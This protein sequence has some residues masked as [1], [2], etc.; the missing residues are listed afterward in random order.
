MIINAFADLCTHFGSDLSLASLNRRIYKDTE[1]GASISV[2]GTLPAA[3]APADAVATQ[4]RKQS[5]EYDRVLPTLM[6]AYA[7]ATPEDRA[8]IEADDALFHTGKPDAIIAWART[9]VPDAFPTATPERVSVVFH[10]GQRDRLPESFLL[11]GFTIQSIVEG[12]DASVNSELFPI[13]TPG[14][15]IDAW[16]ADMEAQVDSLWQEAN[17]SSDEDAED[18]NAAED[19]NSTETPV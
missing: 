11:T 19:P 4:Q 10:N 18:A 12:S 2:Y 3:E 16:M 5:I 13:G 15:Q 17:G 6:A 9:L 14:E 7:K 8:R 1:C